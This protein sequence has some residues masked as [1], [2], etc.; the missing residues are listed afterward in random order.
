VG[1]SVIQAGELM[2]SVESWMAANQDRFRLSQ[3]AEARKM[4]TMGLLENLIQKKLIYEDA[5]RNVPEEGFESLRK[6]LAEH[7]EKEVVPARI[8]ALKVG[9]RRELDEKLQ[10]YG[11]SLARQKQTFIEQAA[12]D[13][14]ERER[15]PSDPEIA[16]QQMDD[17]FQQHRR[18]FETT[19]RAHWEHLRVRIPRYSDGRAAREKLAYL[20]NLV[21]DGASM[22]QALEAQPAGEPMCRGGD[23]GWVSYGSIELSDGMEQVIFNLQVGRLSRIFQDRDGY[24]IVRVVAREEATQPTFE[25]KEIQNEVRERIRQQRS[26]NQRRDYL[27]R[28]RR[29]IPVRTVFDGD[30]ALAQLRRQSEAL[31]R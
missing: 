30:P 31:R 9:S 8:R 5:R 21:K 16:H 14:W 28:L 15:V 2:P 22:A 26:Q 13:V 17:Y 23:Q 10:E 18:D 4:V 12:S 20:G 3:R 7:F 24:H 11:T 19:A 6:R 27:A 29:E 25:D 1:D